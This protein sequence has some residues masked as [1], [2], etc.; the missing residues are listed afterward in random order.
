M[1]HR[2]ILAVLLLLAMAAFTAGCKGEY[3]FSF[4]VEQSL[5]DGKGEW[6]MENDDYSFVPDGLSIQD[7]NAACPKRFS[8]DFTA[9]F[10]F[11]L[12]IDGAHRHTFGIAFSDYTFYSS[13]TNSLEIEFFNAHGDS[14]TYT[15]TESATGIG[16]T[17][18]HPVADIPAF[19]IDGLNELVVEKVGD[20]FTIYL[21]DTLWCTF[22]LEKYDS[23]WFGPNL[24]IYNQDAQNPS[25]GL[26]FESLKVEYNGSVSGTEINI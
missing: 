4:K 7:A 10:L 9:T 8:G 12:N 18:H 16:S 24:F 5:G 1:K 23:R 3:F 6:I 25:Y 2:Y 21:E 26:A 13:P 22:T 14:G 11:R 17:T 20:I 19:D 15:I